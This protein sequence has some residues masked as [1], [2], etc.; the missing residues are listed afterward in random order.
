MVPGTTRNES[1]IGLKRNDEPSPMCSGLS[2]PRR[3]CTTWALGGTT[4]V[5]HRHQP[6]IRTSTAVPGASPV[7][8]IARWR[9]VCSSTC[10][11]RGAAAMG[12]RLIC[13]A[14]RLAFRSTSTRCCCAITC[15][16]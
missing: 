14:A 12:A 11:W 16:M 5:F 2:W 8:T 6:V 9:P 1:S 15:S 3:V 13:I 4:T 7:A 10:C